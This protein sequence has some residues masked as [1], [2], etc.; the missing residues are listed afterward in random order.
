MTM[1]M[2]IIIIIIIIIQVNGYLLSCRLNSTSANYKAS[3]RTQ[4]KQDN[5]T[6]IQKQNTKQTKQKQHCRKKK[7]YKRR[8]WA[9]TLYPEK[10]ID[11]LI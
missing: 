8:I 11:K 10:N 3:T 7:Q 2:I 1:M 6:N 9:K 4:I 5:S